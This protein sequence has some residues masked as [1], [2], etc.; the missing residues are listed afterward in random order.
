MTQSKTIRLSHPDS[1]ATI[2]VNADHAGLYRSQG[3]RNAIPDA[4]TA[5]ATKAEW[6]EF[7]VTKGLD[8]AEAEAM[9]KD[10]LIAAL[11]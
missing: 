5:K 2:E 7:A 11:S 3:W 6:V 8:E 1:G 10:A 4:P 9:T